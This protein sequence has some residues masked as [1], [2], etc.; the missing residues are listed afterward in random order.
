MAMY[1][2]PARGSVGSKASPLLSIWNLGMGATG[3]LLSAVSFLCF[4]CSAA[5]RSEVAKQIVG[6]Q[7]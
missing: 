5:L 1:Y 6:S 3:G 4:A 2:T 7:L